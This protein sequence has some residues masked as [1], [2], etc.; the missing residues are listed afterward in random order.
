MSLRVTDKL[1][2]RLSSMTRHQALH[3]P[4]RSIKLKCINFFWRDCKKI[5]CFLKSYTSNRTRDEIGDLSFRRRIHQITLSSLIDPAGFRNRESTAPSVWAFNGLLVPS[6]LS[7]LK[8]LNSANS[9]AGRQQLSVAVCGAKCVCPAGGLCDQQHACGKET[10]QARV[11]RCD[12]M[13]W[14]SDWVAM[15][16]SSSIHCDV[17]WY[18]AG[19]MSLSVK[20]ERVHSSMFKENRS[21]WCGPYTAARLAADPLVC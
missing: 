21:H 7:R 13:A 16:C 14:Y 19:L 10:E 9:P 12:G 8:D 5:P 18:L 3:V 1:V 20:P 15:L 17:I 6:V 11:P 4:W 2:V